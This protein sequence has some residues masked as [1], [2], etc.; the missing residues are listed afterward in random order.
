MSLSLHQMPD[1]IEDNRQFTLPSPRDI[2]FSGS[3]LVAL[4]SSSGLPI[5]SRKR[6]ATEPVNNSEHNILVNYSLVKFPYYNCS[7][8]SPQSAHFM[9]FLHLESQSMPL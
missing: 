5:F 9:V 2:N 3:H 6:G 7:S 4:T 8:R 1:M